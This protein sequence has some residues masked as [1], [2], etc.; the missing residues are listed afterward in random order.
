MTAEDPGGAAPGAAPP[1]DQQAVLADIARTREQLGETV[2]AL[3]ARADVQA[4]AQEKVTAVSGR[5]RGRARDLRDQVTAHAG[6]RVRLAVAAGSALVIGW[7][8]VR[9]MR[10]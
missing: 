3:T 10:R 2:Q 1:D 7:L 6:Q 4:R 9:W 8:A 5:V